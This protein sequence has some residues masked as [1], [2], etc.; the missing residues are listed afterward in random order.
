MEMPAFLPAGLEEYRGVISDEELIQM[1]YSHSVNMF[2]FFI[3]AADDETWSSNHPFVMTELL[4]YLTRQAFDRRLE[5]QHIKQVQTKI[6]EH[7]LLLDSYL[8][9]DMILGVGGDEFHVNSLLFIAASPFFQDLIRHQ[10]YD[11]KT[12]FLGLNGVS[13]TVFKAVLEFVQTGGVP[14]LW[15]NNEVELR[16]I[17][18]QAD[19]FGLIELG[20]SCEEVLKRYINHESVMPMLI[21]AH[22]DG[23]GLL[24]ASC[25]QYINGL[26]Y[27]V[28]FHDSNLESLVFEFLEFKERSL[29]IFDKI[30]DLITHLIVS[31]TLTEEEV[32]SAV[33]KNCKRLIQLNLSAS[34]IF[35]EKI[36]DAPDNLAELDIS[37][38]NWLD[39]ACLN[40]FFLKFTHLRALNL[41][42]NNQL[43]FNAF[44]TLSKAKHLTDLNISRN[45]GI[46]DEEFKLI[47][48]SCSQLTGLDCSEC[49]KVEDKGFY[50]LAR[51]LTHLQIL[52]LENCQI[53][54]G[55][56]I[57]IAV[58]LNFLESIN[59][60]SCKRLSDR[61]VME[62]VKQSR[63]LKTLNINNIHLR[64][65]T[66][67]EIKRL[68]PYLDLII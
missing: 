6:H 63:S 64:H 67:S 53:S 21:Q 52:N 9:L 16:D 35:S 14:D 18:L 66:I 45:F 51:N 26:F 32:F 68:K 36:F 22:H 40:R 24:R 31:G 49:K 17:H 44:G 13:L 33:I 29:E 5:I 58:K 1:L 56:L 42:D 48:Q 41:K 7:I 54:D 46:H 60:T 43:G 57:E 59:L 39:E 55:I 30:K 50:E 61:G 4:K 8:P 65:E 34:N 2:P 37:S 62:F 3:V 28:K 19:R 11:K 20:N 27:G 47:V 15:K 23:W 38:C 25:Y 12:N 10:L